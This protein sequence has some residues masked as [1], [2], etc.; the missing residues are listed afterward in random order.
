MRDYFKK[1]IIVP[2]L[3]FIVATSAFAFTPKVIG[4]VLATDIRAYING[5]EIKA[6]NIDGSLAV[7]V[8]DL[9]EYGFTTHYDNN[10][11]KSIVTRNYNAI[12]FQSAQSELFDAIVGTPVMN[13]YET[14]ITV[15]LNGSKVN[16]YNVDN[17]MAILFSNLQIYGNY[18]YDNSTRTSN[19]WLDNSHAASELPSNHDISSYALQPHP[20]RLSPSGIKVFNRY[21]A[22]P[23]I[24]NLDYQIA[25]YDQ[26]DMYPGSY[27]ST[28]YLYE[29]ILPNPDLARK[30]VTDYIDYMVSEHGY[31]LVDQRESL[32]SQELGMDID[33]TIQSPDLKYK[34]AVGTSFTLNFT[35]NNY[36]YLV[37]LCFFTNENDESEQ[38]TPPINKPVTTQSNYSSHQDVPNYWIY[39]S[40]DPLITSKNMLVYYG[41]SSSYFDDLQSA[42][43]EQIETYSTSYK[44]TGSSLEIVKVKEFKNTNGTT[45]YV[46]LVESYGRIDYTVISFNEPIV[47]SDVCEG[48]SI[49]N[50]YSRQ[51]GQE[52]HIYFLDSNN[53]KYGNIDSKYS[54]PI[55]VA[56]ENV[57]DISSLKS[58]LQKKYQILYAPMGDLFLDIDVLNNAKNHIEVRVDFRCNGTDIYG[59]GSFGLLSFNDMNGF[60][61]AQKDETIQLLQALMIDISHD[62]SDT[63]TGYN[64]TGSIYHGWFTYP[65]L[66]I[67]YN[68]RNTL[69]WVIYDGRFNWTPENDIIVL[70]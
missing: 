38:N 36:D 23:S 1:T 2:A 30:V 27:S 58:F 40:A 51:I 69:S 12:I 56:K 8:S 35:T 52:N 45:V 29:Y 57:S 19:L 11:R 4:S 63:M 43:F 47:G 26:S 68:F 42:G 61:S 67:D 13:V 28:T 53:Y 55:Y 48:I 70:K 54:D 60:S 10:K 21:P 7:L 34:L 33:R 44:K 14:D 6:Y 24:D 64:V 22:V 39:S 62:I 59:S 50:N 3:F 17:R 25:F 18:I 9:N 20:T 66:K 16:S 41:G 15:E 37:S 32:F 5:A 65:H 31:D 49:L 46:C